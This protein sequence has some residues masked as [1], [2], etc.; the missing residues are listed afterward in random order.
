MLGI[1]AKKQLILGSTYE[2]TV[3]AVIYNIF[4]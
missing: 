4:L 3:F 1:L 2:I